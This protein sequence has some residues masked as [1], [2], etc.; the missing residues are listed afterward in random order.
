[1]MTTPVR[2]VVSP[3][4]PLDGEWRL[5]VDPTDCG[6]RDRWWSA[7]LA[8]SVLTKV[9]WII[10]DAFPAYHGV[11]WYQREVTLPENPH[12][13]GRCLLRFWAVDYKADVW[14]GEAFLGTHEGPETPFVFDVT[15]IGRP[16]VPSHLTVRVLNP[17]NEPIDGMTLKT[18]PHRAKVIPYSAGASYNSGGIVD[19]VELALVPPAYIEDLWVRPDPHTGAIRVEIEARNATERSL[20]AVLT[21]TVATL[22]SGETVDVSVARCDL[23]PGSGSLSAEVRVPSPH[24]WEPADPFLYRVTAGLHA[25]GSFH[26]RSARC[27]FRDFRFE[28]GYFRLN[29]RRLFLR[30]S[31]TVNA[32]PVGQHLAGDPGL[33]Q[34]DILFM[35]TMG[36]NCIR[37]I[38]GGST[39]RQLDL[40]DEMGLLVYQESSASNPME[41]SPQMAERF[42]RSVRELI[43]RD[44][45]HPSIVF[46]GLLNEAP[47]GP[48][49]RH[50]AGMLPLV[51]SLD[52][53]R[54]VM[55]NSGRWDGRLDIGSLCNPGGT[56]WE[57]VL[58]AEGEGA[59]ITGNGA[60]GGYTARVGDAHAYPPVPQSQEATRFLHE[61]GRDTKHVFLTEYGIG[62]AVDLWRIVR[63][64]ERI[65][66]T[67][68]EDARYYRER[69][70]RFLEDWRRWHL[71]EV[72]A[73]PADFF[74]QSARRS[75]SQRTLGLD[76]LR[77]NPSLVGY[78][79]TGM[80]DHVNCGEG[81]FT[82]FR[83]LKPGTTDALFEGLAPLRLCVMVWPEHVY[84]GATARIE[85]ALANE[86]VLPPGEYPVTVR[87][88]RPDGA[89]SWARTVSVRVGTGTGSEEPPLAIPVLDD[90]VAIGGAGGAYRC[91]ATLE[92]G[93]APTGGETILHV[94]DAA[95]MPPVAGEIAR[96]GEDDGLDRWLREHGIRVRRGGAGSPPRKEVILVGSKPE[97]G[98]APAFAALAERIA[99]GSVAVFLCPEVF[100]EGDDAT[101]WLPLRNKGKLGPIHSWLYLKDEWARAHPIFEGLPA[102][103]LMSHS[104]YREIIGPLAWLE[105]DPPAEAVAGAIKAS[106]DYQSGLAVTVNDLGAGRFILNTLDIRRRL[107]SHPAAERL[108]RNMLL[109]ASAAAHGPPADPSAGLEANLAELGYR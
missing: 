58:G 108:L 22:T 86:D 82:L 102:G 6:V 44:R 97:P 75:A 105:Q 92:R 107:G 33:H 5:A 24:L 85:V 106:Q 4:I 73:S 51:R 49:F 71:S 57:T 29:G 55:L 16:G 62:S 69:L 50:A 52:P 100:R 23:P 9:P 18:T 7:P 48:V 2:A 83:E 89:C 54:V 53:D 28:N 59:G 78:S 93:G 21:V 26:E 1:M 60:Y 13:G 64:F 46:W 96:W 88:I 27:G 87:V 77:S 74:A 65:G 17:T 41:G 12:Q 81:L 90:T 91:V 80:V 32:A 38:W 30:G 95:A 36:F 34:R 35:K 45:N 40:C 98:G 109:F 19:T 43:R 68:A 47:D 37:F 63:H 66:R 14:L 99:R 42:D 31:H 84:A 79:L 103:G 67:E 101:R 3:T 11:A 25:D 61:L 70:D 10:Q 56:T 104:Y 20:P 8:S 72:F 94:S 39:R 76:A 15:G